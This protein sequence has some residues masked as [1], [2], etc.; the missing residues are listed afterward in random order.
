MLS[1]SWQMASV[2][3]KFLR[4]GA[5]LNVADEMRDANDIPVRFLKET[6]TNPIHD[7]LFSDNN[8]MWDNFVRIKWNFYARYCAQEGL[9][10]S[11]DLAERVKFYVFYGMYRF[12]RTVRKDKKAQLK[13]VVHVIHNIV[14]QYRSRFVTHV[15]KRF[16]TFIDLIKKH[17]EWRIFSTILVWATHRSF[18]LSPSRRVCVPTVPAT[19][20]E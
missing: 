13:P 3:L 11:M 14:T 19:R 1:H 15:E 4:A 5:V 12:V 10:R 16:K 20:T 8:D 17:P 9:T 18:T 7:H 6:N 2:T